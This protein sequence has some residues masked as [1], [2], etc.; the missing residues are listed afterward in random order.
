MG[1]KSIPNNSD[2]QQDLALLLNATA[3]ALVLVDQQG[4]IQYCNEAVV[5]I[6]GHHCDALIGEHLN[7]LLLPITR[8]KHQQ[9]FTEFFKQPFDRAMG[10]GGSFPASHRSGKTIYV[11]IALSK[12][13]QNSGTY[14]LAT[15]TPAAKLNEA[16]SSLKQ[17]Q[18]NL[19]R[20]INENKRLTQVAENSTDAVFLLD[21]DHNVNW[22]NKTAVSLMNARAID[23]MGIHLLN[24]IS[25]DL[26]KRQLL[27][28]RTALNKGATFN[29]EVT[30]TTTANDTIEIDAALQPV[31]ESDVL[32]GF[33]FTARDV[34]S[35]RRL[36]AQMRENNE[37][38][39][40][41]AR[42]AKLGFY[43]LDLVH[44]KLTWSE[45]VYNIHEIPKN[46]KIVVEEAINYYAPEARPIISR[47]V[48]R[49]MRTG[50]SFDLELPFITA[51][52]RQIWVR[53]VG[54]A[55]F[56]DD[57]PI[58]L[59]GAF[60]DITSLRQAATDAEQAAIAKS[61][62]LANMSHEL[63]TPITGVMGLSE[64]LGQTSLDAQ[65]QKYLDI[66][67]QSSKSL[68]F[69]VNQVLDYAKL[70]SG[71]QK[72]H[73][74]RFNLYAFI[75]EKVSIHQM[76]AQEKGYEFT[77]E[78]AADV[79][80]I[81]FGDADRIGQVVSNL[82]ANAVKFTE[83]GS[84][85]LNVKLLNDDMLCFEITDSGV[86]IKP[87]DID[88]LFNEFQ[89]V[90][91]SFSRKH[92]GTGLGLTISKQLVTLMGGE[93]GVNS[94][95][96]LGSTFWFTI[97][98]VCEDAAPEIVNNAALP[99]TLLLVK[100]E[101][102]AT[103]WKELARNKRN[104]IRAC[105]RVSEV[106]S[107]L[108]N[109]GLWQ[110]VAIIDLSEEIPLSTCLSSIKRVI[111]T[112][113]QYVLNDSILKNENMDIAALTDLGLSAAVLSLDVGDET[114]SVPALIESQYDAL[115][116]WHV[117]KREAIQ[118]D[119]AN[120]RLLIVEDNSVNQL[121]FEEMLAETGAQLTS[122]ENGK[123]ALD[124]LEQNDGSFDL[125][126]MDCQMPIMDGFEATKQ[127][128][129]HKNENIAN[130][131][132]SAATAHG[133]DS[134]IQKCYTVGMNDVLVK[135]FSRKQLLDVIFRNLK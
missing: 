55:E 21:Q 20:R 5:S 31:F 36:E 8:Q 46:E 97:P 108:K 129:A 34:T 106:I 30:I 113:Q 94:E 120:K 43:S 134:D 12:V 2:K 100:D 133:F 70:D 93:I 109:D 52:Q 72:L 6:F 32:Q 68:L 79:P 35:R 102:Q 103:A 22:L 77:L 41:T 65:Q 28:L 29:G 49:C 127:I 121:L 95:F 17:S 42:I 123:Q 84:V 80:Q 14:V 90:D 112:H 101:I 125:V 64:L 76:A 54:Y 61:S 25:S 128:R 126:I 73:E 96:G 57:Q 50:Q 87:N 59:K 51:K 16:T 99:N 71:A 9:L 119:L 92:Q 75:D 107:T 81:I 19:N 105:V 122:A 47:A 60:Q 78:I 1:N 56:R 69:L 98:F 110:I 115:S 117:N 85:S 38:L 132:I 82:S 131:P 18:D 27:D 91:T 88:S 118:T 39:E 3:S 44:N 66:I 89:Q 62:F 10:D 74:A 86:G 15:I 53:S 26:N 83:D 23:V 130:L 58:K 124:I 63:R 7:K 4:I 111:N 33:Y 13:V 104:K 37:L 11:S 45:E 67:N 135:P 40:T 116:H 114:T 24:F 48:E